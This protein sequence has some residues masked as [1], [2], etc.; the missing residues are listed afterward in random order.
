MAGGMRRTF[1]MAAEK[2]GNLCGGEEEGFVGN[3][4]WP[5]T[6]IDLMHLALIDVHSL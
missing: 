2:N 5:I 4:R 1:W 6:K 3:D